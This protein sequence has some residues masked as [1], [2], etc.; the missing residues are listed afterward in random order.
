MK[1][2]GGGTF[3]PSDRFVYFL[4]CAP[5]KSSEY[6]RAVHPNILIAANV[7]QGD[8]QRAFLDESLAA[9]GVRVFLDS[10]V[11]SL[12]SEHARKHKLTISEAI[13][14]P[15]EQLD[16]FAALWATYIALLDTYADRLWGYVELDL[17][18]AA[19]K[20]Q[21]RAK[22]EALGFTPIPVYHPLADGWDYFDELAQTYDRICVGNIV[23]ADVA[24]RTRI[25]ATMWERH[26]AYP[27]LWIHLLGYTPDEKLNAFPCDSTD[28]SKW[29]AGRRFDGVNERI[30]L[31]SFSRVEQHMKYVLGSDPA[32][33]VGAY[34]TDMMAAYSAAVNQRNWR[35]HLAAIASLGCAVYPAPQEQRA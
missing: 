28:S 26:R 24:T 17:G 2:T 35:N 15:P 23:G 34:K 8:T 12:A 18:G 7:L 3:D 30:D 31:R 1:R 9:P 22:I 33:E 29:L 6:A 10:G 13:A 16:G 5:G 32:S 25:A 14:L 4:A 19:V 11:F 21:T 20:R 27:D